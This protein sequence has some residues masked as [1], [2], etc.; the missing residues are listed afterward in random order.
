MYNLKVFYLVQRSQSLR[1]R[2]NSSTSRS[3]IS[4]STRALSS[5]GGLS[6]IYSVSPS[7]DFH[8]VYERIHP[9]V[10]GEVFNDENTFHCL[11]SSKLS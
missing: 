7:I 9:Y 6:E 5:S 2:Q 10:S 1:D 8:E 3:T 4:A 11:D